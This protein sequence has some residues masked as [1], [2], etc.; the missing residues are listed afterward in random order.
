LDASSYVD[1]QG[2]VFHYEGEVYRC[3]HPD[4]APLYRTLL[5]G[6]VLAALE[7]HGLV[8]TRKA[9][10]RIEDSPDGLVLH[11]DRVQPLSYCVEWCPSMLRDAALVTLELALAAIDHDLTLQDAYPWNVLFDGAR[12]VF[13]DVTSLVPPDPYVLW[14]AHDQYEAF[15]YRPL[16]LASQGHGDVARALLYNN[17]TGVSL[18]RFVRLLSTG[19]RLRHPGLGVAR[20]ADRR[21]QKSEFLRDKVRRMTDRLRAYVTPELRAR[22]FRRLVRR[23]RA[24]TFAGNGDPWAD[25]Y[26]EIGDEFDKEL[27]VQS[28]RAFLEQFAPDTVLDLGC[29]TGVFSIVAA[30]CGARVVSVDS[31]ERCIELLFA[32]AKRHN[33]RIT[34]LVG[35]ALCPTP[36]YGFLG[37]QYPR[38]CD[39]V[40]SDAVLC[41]GLMHHL[42][43]TGRQSWDRIVELLD[44]FTRRRLIFEFVAM[45][46]ANIGRLPQRRDIDY[47][48]DTVVAA[49]KTRFS[50]VH[51][52]PSDRET[53]KLLVCVK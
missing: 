33:L 42:H 52:H 12:A 11:H 31:S 9:S 16:A 15:F 49:L 40:R 39:R 34:P 28:V 29:N 23:V 24:L 17:I 20:W 50:E 41:L 47:S 36:A 1:P 51:V 37:R 6:G 26:S 22:F 35:D 4:S 18:D 46:D 10:L 21:L 38:L 45:D 3:V 14:P 25:Y 32:E 8:P 7:D 27:K 30:E 44:V 53:R 5:D 48:L 2:Y 43:L 13:V 19:Y